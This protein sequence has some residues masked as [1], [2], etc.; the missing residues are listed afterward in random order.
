MPGLPERCTK[1]YPT[2]LCQANKS[3]CSVFP[4][5]THLQNNVG[6]FA[7]AEASLGCDTCDIGF[8]S[9]EGQSFC[10]RA[11]LTYYLTE[12][13]PI[14]LT[15]RCPANA[16]CA[17]GEQAPAPVKGFWVDRSSYAYSDVL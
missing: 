2:F 15:A 5:S 10:A 12:F 6:K 4:V 1:K 8:D 3:S 11:A 16:Q 7:A 17:G 14:P 9:L 13:I